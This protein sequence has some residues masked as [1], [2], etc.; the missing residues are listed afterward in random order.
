MLIEA[1]RSAA[2]IQDLQMLHAAVNKLFVASS[3]AS[4]GPLQTSLS[5]SATSE[6]LNTPGPRISATY[7]V[8]TDM[9]DETARRT[10]GDEGFS[11]D[12]IASLYQMTRLRS[13]RSKR[14]PASTN[15]TNEPNMR[16]N[17]PR[18]LISRG[19]LKWADADRLARTFLSKT[20][21]YLYGLASKYKDTESIRDAS[22]LLLTAI[23]TVSAL[24]DSTGQTCYRVCDAELRRL[25]SISIFMPQ[26]S[27]EDFR[28]LCIACFWLS[29]ISWQV[30]GLAIRRGIEFDL[31]KSYNLVVGSNASDASL[32]S[33]MDITCQNEAVDCVRLWYLFYICD[34]HSSVL[35]GRPST[36]HEQESIRDWEAYLSAVQ[37]TNMD[38]RIVSQVALLRILNNVSMLFGPNLESRIPTVFKPELNRFNK[39]LDQWVTTWLSRSRKSHSFSLS[40]GLL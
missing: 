29:D 26:V 8:E 19:L 32:S 23:C 38:I 21:H 16:V 5:S 12:P 18:D 7:D 9:L 39:Q 37:D 14:L 25:V 10:I 40:P 35:Y 1:F 36:I 30:S 33:R 4:L 20:D 24:H 15:E 13:L 27:V 17:R 31:H 34:Q 22:P 6:A 11:Q 28:G 3:G 2:I